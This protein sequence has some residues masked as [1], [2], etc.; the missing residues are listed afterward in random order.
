M[1]QDPHVTGFFSVLDHLR[2]FNFVFLCYYSSFGF[3]RTHLLPT[4]PEIISS[5]KK[6]KRNTKLMV[7][8]YIDLVVVCLGANS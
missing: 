4:K 6:E 5:Q 8:S 7:W 2:I 3:C 1:L